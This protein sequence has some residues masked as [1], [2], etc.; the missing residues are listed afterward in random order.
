MRTVHV[1]DPALCCSSG[2]CG[3]DVDQA[4]VD[5][6]AAVK[7]VE[8]EGVQVRRHNLASEPADFA[9][10]EVVRKFLEVSGV[11]GLPVVVVD[12]V[13]ALSGVYPTVEQLRMFAGVAVA[14]TL[15]ALPITQESDGC[16]CGGTC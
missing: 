2:V 8:G 4:L 13:L 9:T 14:P 3:A 11:D 16:C 5:F 10:S 6:A 7:Q 1:Y 12:D 15:G